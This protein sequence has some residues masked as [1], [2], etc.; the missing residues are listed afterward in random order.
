MLGGGWLSGA[1]GEKVEEE[2]AAGRRLIA[3]TMQAVRQAD[4]L[5]AEDEQGDRYVE[6]RYSISNRY[7]CCCC[8]L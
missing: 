7:C 6:E 1:L 2:L 3:D 8:G 4:T 5:P